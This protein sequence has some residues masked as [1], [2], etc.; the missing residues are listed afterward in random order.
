MTEDYPMHCS[1]NTHDLHEASVDSAISKFRIPP[2]M[3]MARLETLTAHSARGR[4]TFLTY[5]S[6]AGRKVPGQ[7]AVRLIR[8]FPSWRA[9]RPKS[10]NWSLSNFVLRGLCLVLSKTAALLTLDTYAGLIPQITRKHLF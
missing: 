7:N 3:L 8:L 4:P 6:V 10:S 1:L 5:W 2:A 9:T